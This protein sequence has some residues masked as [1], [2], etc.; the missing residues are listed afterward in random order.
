MQ[1]L[2][3]GATGLIGSAL[4]ARLYQEGHQ[5][6]ACVRTAARVPA[7]AKVVVVDFMTATFEDW[8]EHLSDIDAVVNCVGVLQDSAHDSVSAAHVEGPSRLFAA[9]EKAGVRRV[10]HFSAMGV[11]RQTPSSFSRTK[12]AGDDDLATRELDW[13]IL[14]PSVVVGRAA[15]GGSALFRGL[16]A[17]PILPAMPSTGSLQIVQLDQVI[18]SVLLFLRPEAPAR[19]AVEI[20]GPDRL[21]LIETV[22]AFRDWLGGAPQRIVALPNWLSTLTYRAGD[23]A[24]WLGWRPPVRSTAQAEITRGATGDSRP[25]SKL[26]GITPTSLV[27]ALKANPASVQE[28][29]FANLYL[30]KPLVFGVLSVF[31]IGTGLIALGPGWEVGMGYLRAGGAGDIGPAAIVAGSLADI[32]IGVGIAFRRTARLALYAAIAISL[33][34]ALIGT[35]LVPQLWADPLGPMLKIWPIIVLIM[36]ALAIRGDR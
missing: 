26:T 19:L 29:W 27:D 35:V 9:C 32:A 8:I 23:F 17:L 21:S 2:V 11:D 4:V 22:R 31:W 36:V 30:L 16:A 7:A 24:G 14:R 13:V 3:T 33:T 6:V 28:R 34:Y 20:A 5:P 10:I 15:Y 1:V 25:W 18:D 12:R